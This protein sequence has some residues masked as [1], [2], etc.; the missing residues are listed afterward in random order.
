V[1]SQL[2]WKLKL[3][4]VAGVLGAAIPGIFV[5]WVLLLEQD[6]YDLRWKL[7]PG[8]EFRYR[9]VVRSGSQGSDEASQVI[10][11]R[12]TIGTVNED[13]IADVTS[14]QERLTIHQGGPEG[15][16]AWDSAS[17]KPAPKD[18]AIAAAAAMTG[19]P[20]KYRVDKRGAIVSADG[21]DA[22]KKRLREIIGGD[23]AADTS[24]S[25]TGGA[26]IG[27]PLPTA[28]V[29]T[30]TRWT[31][32]SSMGGAGRSVLEY[33]LRVVQNG[34]ATIVLVGSKSAEPA[35]ASEAK[36][37]TPPATKHGSE[38]VSEFAL[39][40]GHLVSQVGRSWTQSMLPDGKPL[41]FEFR[42]ETK[43]VERKSKD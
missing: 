21:F 12:Y 4:T 22:V 19:I 10:L 26:I 42:S 43:L 32:E 8:E 20:I 14:L 2:D 30:G 5:L 31:A 16:V 34:V 37:A 11:S 35:K 7:H 6:Q 41:R 29:T 40:E 3:G 39:G 9:T 24:V 36:S 15:P 27:A 17:G 1:F 18:Y 38:D 28:P 33:S 13:G 23:V 25:A